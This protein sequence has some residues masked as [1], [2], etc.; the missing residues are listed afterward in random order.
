MKNLVVVK[1]YFIV[2]MTEY[3]RTDKTCDKEQIIIEM[4][5]W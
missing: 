4:M 3:D 1:E 2:A 5:I